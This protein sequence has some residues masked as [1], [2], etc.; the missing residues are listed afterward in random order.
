MGEFAS[1]IMNQAD[2]RLKLSSLIFHIKSSP[3]S[4][5]T[6][7]IFCFAALLKIV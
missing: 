1:G 7:K 5:C 6:L 3:L 4:G 2:K